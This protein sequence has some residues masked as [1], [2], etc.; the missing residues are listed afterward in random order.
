MKTFAIVAAVAYFA[1]LL[2]GSVEAATPDQHEECLFW[3]ES[4]ECDTVSRLRIGI[5]SKIHWDTPPNIE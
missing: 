4:G 5:R 2:S 3:A 1:T